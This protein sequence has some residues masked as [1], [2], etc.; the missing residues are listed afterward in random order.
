MNLDFANWYGIGIWWLT[1]IVLVI[2]G[3][4]YVVFG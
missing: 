4:E 2:F 3:N 1:D